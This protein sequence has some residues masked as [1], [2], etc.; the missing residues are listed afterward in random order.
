[1]GVP[2]QVRGV[3]FRPGDLLHGDENGVLLVPDGVEE[4]LPQAVDQ[5]RIH[6]RRLIAWVRSEHSSRDHLCD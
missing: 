6:E 4:K 2:V 3:V 1:V 5:V